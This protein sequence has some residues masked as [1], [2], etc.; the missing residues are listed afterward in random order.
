MKEY[1]IL[2]ILFFFSVDRI[3]LVISQLKC[4][5][6]CD[7]ILKSILKFYIILCAMLIFSV[8][9]QF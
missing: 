5:D 9:V 4:G 3:K 6:R 8:L 2:A 1:F 7:V